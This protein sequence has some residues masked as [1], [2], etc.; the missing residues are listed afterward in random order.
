MSSFTSFWNHLISSS[1][2]FV[3]LEIRP[4]MH[5]FLLKNLIL[6]DWFLSTPKIT[7]IWHVSFICTNKKLQYHSINQL[8][9]N[10]VNKLQYKAWNDLE[11]LK[12]P[13][14]HFLFS[15]FGKAV[16]E[17]VAQKWKWVALLLFFWIAN[18]LKK[19]CSIVLNSFYNFFSH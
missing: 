9:L 1:T 17:N 5:Y 16:Q 2:S 14:L 13:E 6:V 3:V 8:C 18:L 4:S 12:F 10:W 19:V 7:S 11:V 15:I